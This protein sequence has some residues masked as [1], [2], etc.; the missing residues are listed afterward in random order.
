MSERPDDAPDRDDVP[1]GQPPVWGGGALDDAF[2][3]GLFAWTAPFV[4]GASLAFVLVGWITVFP[5]LWVVGFGAVG[6][7]LGMLGRPST[8][9]SGRTAAL[10]GR[11]LGIA[12]MAVGAYAAIALVT[13]GV[14][15]MLPNWFVTVAAAPTVGA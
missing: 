8:H 11:I 6:F 5:A 15:P 1:S 4:G 9:P 12:A 2:A 10:V 13:G 7:A 14:L 3:V